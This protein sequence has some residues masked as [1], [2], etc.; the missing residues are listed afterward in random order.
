VPGVEWIRLNHDW[1]GW[2]SKLELFAP[3][4]FADGERVLYIDLDT[5]ILGDLYDIA[6]R[7]EEFIGIGDFYRRPP[8]Q[9]E[10]GF[11]SGLML[12]TAGVEPQIHSE[13]QY[14]FRG[15]FPGG[16]QQWMESV[17]TRKPAL[18]EFLVPDQVVSYKVHC[19]HKPPSGARV[20]CFHGHPKPSQVMD[21]WVKTLRKRFLPKV[22]AGVFA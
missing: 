4:T 18:W 20:V 7:T 3:Q 12:W 22:V 5:I 17:L 6:N 9:Q 13:F 1:E 14:R 8:Y 11:G 2:W 10:I 16:D 19:R 21:P 15:S